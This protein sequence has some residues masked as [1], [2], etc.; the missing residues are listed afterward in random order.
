MIYPYV[1][2]C[3]TGFVSLGGAFSQ[4]YLLYIISVLGIMIARARNTTL[5]HLCAGL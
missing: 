2:V 3:V 5:L 4:M 1:A